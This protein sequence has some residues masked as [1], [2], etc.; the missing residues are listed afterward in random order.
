M[1][2]PVSVVYKDAEEDRL[3]L[4]CLKADYCCEIAQIVPTFQISAGK[5]QILHLPWS[6]KG[7]G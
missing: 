3:V 4:V 7:E 1:Q 6:I 5:A 2:I